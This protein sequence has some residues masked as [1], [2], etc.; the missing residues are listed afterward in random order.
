MSYFR[1]D[2]AATATYTKENIAKSNA[3]RIFMKY[4]VTATFHWDYLDQ[5]VEVWD[6]VGEVTYLESGKISNEQVT[7]SG[8]NTK[9]QVQHLASLAQQLLDILITIV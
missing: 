7:T 4:Q 3:G 9:K 2:I 6:P 8:N 1:S 5:T